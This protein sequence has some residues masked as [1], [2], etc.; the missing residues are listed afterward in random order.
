MSF[1]EWING[2]F[3]NDLA[4]LP[5]YAVIF[6]LAI[7]IIIIAGYF[8]E[9][10]HL[11]YFRLNMKKKVKIKFIFNSIWNFYWQVGDK[12]DYIGMKRKQNHDLLL[13]GIL[14]GLV[15]II[16]VATIWDL[17]LLLI[18]PYIVGSWRDIKN[19]IELNPDID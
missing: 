6:G 11:I 16:L 2:T 13:C 9:L 7:V 18:I 19:I 1:S 10:G 14:M 5:M 17:Y 4:L 12:D 3:Y 8:H 15:P